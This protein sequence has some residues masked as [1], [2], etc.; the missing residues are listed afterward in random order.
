MAKYPRH[1]R[2]VTVVYEDVSLNLCG[3][4]RAKLGYCTFP[5]FSEGI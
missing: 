4:Q 3:F 5:R 2:L 1:T